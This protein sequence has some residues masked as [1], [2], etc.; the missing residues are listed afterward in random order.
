MNRQYANSNYT[1]TFVNDLKEGFAGLELMRT[2]KGK[3][4]QVARIIFWD[5]MG[6]F[7]IETLG[8]DLPLAIVEELIAEAKVVVS[9][10]EEKRS[11]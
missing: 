4:E 8:V 5:A 2:S 1:T 3:T 10:P 6:Q 11:S 9:D 7:F